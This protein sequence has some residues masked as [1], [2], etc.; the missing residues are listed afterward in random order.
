VLAVLAGAVVACAV[1]LVAALGLALVFH[2]RQVRR[3][4]EGVLSRYIPLDSSPASGTRNLAKTFTG[5]DEPRHEPTE[6]VE[7]RSNSSRV[8]ALVWLLPSDTIELI[9]RHAPVQGY[10]WQISDS[11]VK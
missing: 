4:V 7:T 8:L 9:R 10:V 2:R 5:T 6:A 11:V 3:D 1:L